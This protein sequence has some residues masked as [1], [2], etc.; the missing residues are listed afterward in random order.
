MSISASTYEEISVRNTGSKTAEFLEGV[1]EYLEKTWGIVSLKLDIDG[2]II[3]K[4][5]I[6]VVSADSELCNAL[7]D[8]LKAKEVRLS[9]RSCN[10]GGAAWRLDLP[11]LKILAEN[12]CMCDAVSYRS[13]DH[14]DCDS[15]VDSY[16]FDEKGLRSVQEYTEGTDAVK[17]I[18]NWYCETP[19]IHIT[20]EDATEDEKAHE[21]LVEKLNQLFCDC[22]GVD[23]DDL[24]E[25]YEDSWEDFGEIVINGAVTFSGDKLDEIVSICN[26]IANIVGGIESAQFT[27][28]INAIPDSED[29]Y[30]FAVCSFEACDGV[31]KTRSVKF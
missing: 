15:C 9:L 2:E 30:D 20:C 10:G 5:D 7:N 16:I 12:P 17:D 21:K 31:I 18:K 1:K 29:N 24:E 19:E 27:L 11:F 8:L 25:A 13:T 14:Y 26:D 28:S 23:E 3:K 22:F 6:D 4:E